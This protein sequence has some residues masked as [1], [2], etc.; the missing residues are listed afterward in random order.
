MKNLIG[1]FFVKKLNKTHK[2]SLEKYVQLIVVEV[3]KDVTQ[4][5]CECRL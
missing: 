3:N 1:S 2:V 4:D 5:L